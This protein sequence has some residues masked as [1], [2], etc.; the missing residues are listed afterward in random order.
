VLRLDA[1]DATL[2]LR[3]FSVLVHPQP[4]GGAQLRPSSRRAR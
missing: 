1:L 3:M 4:V 2:D